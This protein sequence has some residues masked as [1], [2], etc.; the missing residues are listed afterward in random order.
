MIC[1]F[2][3]SA[4]LSFEILTFPNV[5]R[6]LSILIDFLTIYVFTV[7]FQA[8]FQKFFWIDYKGFLKTSLMF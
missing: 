5:N 6:K 1:L 8:P 4:C 7:Y 2:F 3:H